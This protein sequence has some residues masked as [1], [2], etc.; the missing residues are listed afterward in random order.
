MLLKTLLINCKNLRNSYLV[1][2]AV[3]AAVV[4]HDD[5]DEL[6]WELLL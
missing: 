3:A 2:A 5:H 6:Y 4:V 1:A